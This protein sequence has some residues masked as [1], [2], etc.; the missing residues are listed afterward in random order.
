MNRLIGIE[1]F[2]VREKNRPEKKL[3]F[4]HTRP[5]MVSIYR[6]C[7][8]PLVSASIK[9]EKRPENVC[10]CRAFIMGITIERPENKTHFIL[11][12]PVVEFSIE[13]EK[14]AVAA[15]LRSAAK[16]EQERRIAFSFASFGK[17]DGNKIR[18]LRC[19]LAKGKKIVI[20]TLPLQSHR[21]KEKVL[22]Q[23]AFPD[24]LHHRK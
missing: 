1:V 18:L 17:I 24:F 14:T 7:L 22:R 6:P 3:L 13:R 21:K 19:D 20:S 2:L 23:G 12:E 5:F 15:L 4:S 10:F 8:E 11:R 16:K 9:R